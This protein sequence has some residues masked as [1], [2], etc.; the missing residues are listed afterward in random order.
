MTLLSYL[1]PGVIL[2]AIVAYKVY[3]AGQQAR[4]DLDA[5]NRQFDETDEASE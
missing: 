5:W 1:I 4:R 2:A 3:E